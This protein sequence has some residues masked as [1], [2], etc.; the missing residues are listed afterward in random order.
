[1]CSWRARQSGRH[2]AVGSLGPDV[3]ASSTGSW[4]GH[5]LRRGWA[6]LSDQERAR[7]RSRAPLR[8][9]RRDDAVRRSLKFFGAT[10]C[11]TRGSHVAEALLARGLPVSCFAAFDYVGE[12]GA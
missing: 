9:R 6:A 10:A 4:L 2:R 3:C 8:L 1:M 5:P 12:T 7:A 11:A